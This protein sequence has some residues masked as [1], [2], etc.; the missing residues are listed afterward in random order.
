MVK[1]VFKILNREIS[2][3][4]EAAYLLGFFAIL[5]Q[6][7]ALIRDRFFASY[8]G[9]GST[10]DIYYAS[11]RIPDIILVTAASMVSVSILIPFLVEKMDK[12]PEQCSGQGGGVAK[13]FISEIFTVFFLFILALSALAFILSPYLL[14]IL[15]PGF[16]PELHGDLVF[17]TR[18]MLLQPILL[19]ISN[20]FGCIVQ[21]NRKFFVYALSP[22][23]YNLGIILGI[24][25]FYPFYGIGGLAGGVVLGAFLH[26]SIQI[27]AVIATGLFPVFT[28]QINFREIWKVAMIS[29]PR[30]LA[31]GA[32][33][34]A[35]LFLVSLGSLVGAG[36]IAIFTLS[37][38]L[39]SVPL[40]IVGA[41]YSLAAFPTLVRAFGIPDKSEFRGHVISALTHIIF[42]SFPV[43]SLFIVLRAQI[44]RTILGYGKF[45]WTDTRLVS[46]SLAIFSLS[47]VAQGVALLFIRAYYA[48]GKTKTPLII[49][50]LSSALIIIFG[51]AFIKIFETNIGIRYFLESLFKVSNLPGTAVLMLP[52]A[53]SFATIL[54]ALILWI[55]FE[56]DFGGIF[57]SIGK[58]LFQVFSASVIMGF[59]AYLFLGVFDD[60]FNIN[61]VIGIF[62]QGFLSGILGIIGGAS[63]LVLLKNTEIKEI[64]RTL[65]KK[66][67]KVPAKS[68]SGSTPA[69]PAV[70]S[71]D[72]SEIPGN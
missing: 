3:L 43:L 65:H 18:V 61:T 11:F 22:V 7:L 50:L 13:R 59:V 14:K 31:L 30:T 10:L 20:L 5:S 52:L 71:P 35:T 12:A 56:K 62:M 51:Y 24:V 26:L 48:G 66:I 40:A 63:L 17:T 68:P 9:A 4:H 70:V 49:N 47:V 72:T 21:A 41:S 55:Y 6:L 44:V 28:S 27:P 36:S 54:N 57:R 39:Q 42:W 67:W 32:G 46:A 34:L 45:S 38:N 15:F 60:I 64:W 69:I 29:L 58:S 33:N 23:L 19:G 8:F 2:G 16:P 53:Y 37:W 25:F 1:R